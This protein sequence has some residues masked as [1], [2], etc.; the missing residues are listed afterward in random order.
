MLKVS[1]LNCKVNF[2]KKIGN[3]T[4]GHSSGCCSLYKDHLGDRAIN[5]DIVIAPGVKVLSFFNRTFGYEWYI[6]DIPFE[7][8]L[9]E[10]IQRRKNRGV[11][12]FPDFTLKEIEKIYRPIRPIPGSIKIE[13][14]KKL[15]KEDDVYKY[16]NVYRIP[17]EEVC[18]LNEEEASFIGEDEACYVFSDRYKG[19]KGGVK[20]D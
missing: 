20:I 10:E 15:K 19:Y 8:T 6:E 11:W 14:F 9:Q 18:Y 7:K 13:I 1:S 12:Y 17:W 3:Y 5:L 2:V 16:H 4:Y